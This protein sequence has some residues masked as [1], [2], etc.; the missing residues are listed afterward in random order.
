[1]N[2]KKII[3]TIL[4]FVFSFLLIVNISFAQYISI[5]SC[6]VPQQDEHFN[7]ANTY[8]EK[9]NLKYIYS[10]NEDSFN[11]ID[12]YCN[13]GYW[14]PSI[15]D[16]VSCIF[17]KAKLKIEGYSKKV[18]FQF[19]NKLLQIVYLTFIQLKL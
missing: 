12:Y 4:H 6:V 13:G 14:Q 5:P 2:S 3:S 19:D 7:F 15:F 9:T 16:L 17:P 8:L 10:I 11:V 18:H 1:M